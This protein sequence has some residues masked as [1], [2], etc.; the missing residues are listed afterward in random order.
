MRRIIV[1]AALLS[2]WLQF[3][4]GQIQSSSYDSLIV[5]YANPKSY[6]IGAITVSGTQ[7][8]DKDILIALAGIKVGDKIDIPSQE[9]S[10][11]LKNLWKQD[12]FANV[13]IYADHLNGD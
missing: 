11:A 1:F 5:D 8:L 6:I 10:K 2:G 9:I 13:K 4:S 7:Y 3:A 12:L